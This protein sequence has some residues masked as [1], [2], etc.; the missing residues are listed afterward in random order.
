[1]SIE[2]WNDSLRPKVTGTWNIHNAFI[3]TELDFFLMLSSAVGALGN[4]SQ[5]AYAA[6][7]TF[8][9]SFAEYRKN[10][11]LPATSAN[12]GMVAGIGYV[13]E[14][15]KIRETLVRQGFDE[16]NEDELMAL[17]EAVFIKKD[18][19]KATGSIITGLGVW[20]KGE[21]RPIFA[22]PRLSHFRRM[23]LGTKG[24]KQSG[25][26]NTVAVREALRQSDSLD[27]AVKVTC[28]AIIAKLSSLLM[29][30]LE[31]I[32]PSSSMQ[33]YGMD[34]LVAVEMRNW[35][36]SNLGAAISVLELVGNESINMLSTNIVKKSTFIDADAWDH[37][38]EEV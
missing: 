28:E 2:D 34:S 17:L 1:M 7:S 37:V 9:D 6:A 16:I 18:R 31:E 4:A 25:I 5:A 32:N 3:Q 38:H 30:P 13:A 10:L 26:N 35:I 12:L 20:H 29:V 24:E 8:L 14:N 19:G 11:G 33:D 15:D 22:T 21:M 23:T 27:K 36:T